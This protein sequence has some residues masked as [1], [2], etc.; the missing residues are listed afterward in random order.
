MYEDEIY[1]PT[2]KNFEEDYT[3]SVLGFF[4]YTS[5]GEF[6]ELPSTYFE[7]G[8]EKKIYTTHSFLFTVNSKGEFYLKGRSSL[9]KFSKNK[10]EKIEIED[11]DE[12]T[13]ITGITFDI[14]D[15]LWFT[16]SIYYLNED[17]EKSKLIK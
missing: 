17:I 2:R 11:Y 6:I 14:Y 4:K 15:N 9:F 12:K 5:S 10:W 8:K 1:I 16:T 7:N 13:I 3:V